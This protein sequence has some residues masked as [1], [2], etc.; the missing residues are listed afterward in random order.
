MVVIDEIKK[1]RYCVPVLFWYVWICLGMLVMIG[2][3]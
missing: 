1:E 3:I 2:Y